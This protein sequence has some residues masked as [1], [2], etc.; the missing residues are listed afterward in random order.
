MTSQRASN[1]LV[2]GPQG[3]ILTRADLPP[4]ESVRWT[5]HRKTEIVA[6][7]QGGLL[8]LEEA[9]E[10]YALT[11]DEFVSWGADSSK[12]RPRR[13]GGRK[14]AYVER[15]VSVQKHGVSDGVLAKP[16]GLP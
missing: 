13:I 5:P 7:I 12:V 14:H 3:T 8:S 6:A 10:R 1:C 16:C 9:C 2:I 15:A 4:T 11:I